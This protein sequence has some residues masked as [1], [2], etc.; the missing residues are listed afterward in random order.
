MNREKC[1]FRWRA[2]PWLLAGLF[3][4]DMLLGIA[5]ADAGSTKRITEGHIDSQCI[6][7][8]SNP[9]CAVETWI[10]C[11]AL[12]RPKLCA[13]LGV[14]GM[15]FETDVQ[16]NIFEYRIIEVLPV[17]PDLIPPQLRSKPWYILAQLEI[18]TMDRW[19]TSDCKRLSEDSFVPFVYYLRSEGSKWRLAAWTNDIS[20]TCEYPE[21]DHP[22]CNLFFWDNDSP[23]VH[24]QYMNRNFN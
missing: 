20:V 12:E 15:R 5:P 9:V 19:C 1:L 17:T 23:W 22:A 4:A 21:P 2:L 16:P 7:D 14:E 6:G 11:Y 3:A 13:L 18:R 10:A 8:V 24:D